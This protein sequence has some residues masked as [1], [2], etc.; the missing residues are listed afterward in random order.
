MLTLIKLAPIFILTAQAIILHC[1]INFGF[2]LG[3][4]SSLLLIAAVDIATQTLNLEK[5]NLGMVIFIQLP[6][7]IFY[8]LRH[9][10]LPIIAP[11][12]YLFSIIIITTLSKK[13]SRNF[14]TK[15]V[16]AIKEAIRQEK[17]NK[18]PRAYN[19]TLKIFE[20]ARKLMKGEKI[21]KDTLISQ[22]K[23]VRQSLQAD[24]WKGGSG[25]TKYL[26]AY[27][28]YFCDISTENFEKEKELLVHLIKE[29][30][31]NHTT[32]VQE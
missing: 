12:L 31:E 16:R 1:F 20:M 22:L 2:F 7:I 26:I 3:F 9:D 5:K 30:Y 24:S 29:D 11:I 23:F 14:D 17:I 8:S 6:I 10:L 28:A 4:L 27:F 13:I 15:A 18:Y 25:K 32:A 19:E 21:N